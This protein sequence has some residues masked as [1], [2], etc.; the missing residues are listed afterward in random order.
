MGV[1]AN[2]TIDLEVVST[3]P[4]NYPIKGV[5]K[6]QESEMPDVITVRVVTGTHTRKSYVRVELTLASIYTIEFVLL[7]FLD[8]NEVKDIVVEIERPTIR[9]P[10]LGG[11]RHKKNGVEYHNASAQT[12]KKPRPPNPIEVFER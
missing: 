5:K 2:D 3:D 4:I 1:V 10:F 9:K 8:S 12:M 6:R 7:L 11:F